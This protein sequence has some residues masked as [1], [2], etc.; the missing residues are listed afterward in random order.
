MAYSLNPSGQPDEN[1]VY[2][3]VFCQ[4]THTSYPDQ[5]VETEFENVTQAAAE[6][7]GAALDAAVQANPAQYFGG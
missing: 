1:G 3:K 4:I 2:R 6:D 5:A 7:L